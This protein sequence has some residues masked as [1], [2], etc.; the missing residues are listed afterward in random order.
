MESPVSAARPLGK[1]K[2]GRD[3]IYIKEL[4][5][6]FRRKGQY[7]YKSVL[8]IFLHI[9]PVL[10]FVSAWIMQKRRERLSTDLGYARRLLA[11]KKAK[12]GLQEA[13]H[14]LRQNSP[15]EFYDALFRTVREY[16]GNRCHVPAG[17]ITSD[18]AVEVLKEKAVDQDLLTR[19][20]NVISE[21]DMARYAP[22]EL[23][24]PRMENAL[25]EVKE[26][27]DYLER[28]KG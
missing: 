18:V 3:I 25:R 9:L 27:I 14:F 21:C 16:I 7:F 24:S 15:A 19:L 5:G 6:E 17:G 26:I 12:K 10:A 2:F 11:P 22:S 20:K 28:Y 4:P 8:F 13:E 23:D 1:E